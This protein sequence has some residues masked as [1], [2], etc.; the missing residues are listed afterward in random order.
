MS[1]MSSPGQNARRS[2]SWRSF[3]LF[4][5]QTRSMPTREAAMESQTSLAV[6]LSTRDDTISGRTEARRESSTSQS[7]WN[8]ASPNSTAS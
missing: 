8:S 2:H 7:S 4:A 5:F 1:L 3:C 6:G